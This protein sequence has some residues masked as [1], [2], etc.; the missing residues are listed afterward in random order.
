MFFEATFRC[1][2]NFMVQ[3]QQQ[4]YKISSCTCKKKVHP[5]KILSKHDE[6]Q[7]HVHNRLFA[8]P[9]KSKKQVAMIYERDFCVVKKYR[10]NEKERKVC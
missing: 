6:F 3:K 9:S 7:I 5:I 8:F 2:E 1:M 4:Q 10:L